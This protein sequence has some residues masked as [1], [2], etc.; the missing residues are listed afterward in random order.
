MILVTNI[1]VVQNGGGF[2]LDVGKV[3]FNGF[4][5]Q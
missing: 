4:N 1:S 5:I 2:M 3:E